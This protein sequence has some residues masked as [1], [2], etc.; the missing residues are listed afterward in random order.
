MPAWCCGDLGPQGSD[1]CPACSPLSVGSTDKPRP[2]ER[3]GYLRP[4]PQVPPAPSNGVLTACPHPVPPICSDPLGPRAP[5]EAHGSGL[6]LLSSGVPS[7]RTEGLGDK[8]FDC[9]RQHPALRCTPIRVPCHPLCPS[10]SLPPHR[11]LRQPGTPRLPLTRA[12]WSGPSSTVY[13]GARRPSGV[14]PPRRAHSSRPRL[15]A[16]PCVTRAG[17]APSA[18][19]PKTVRALSPRSRN[20]QRAAS[21]HIPGRAGSQGK[22]GAAG[23][24]GRGGG[25]ERAGSGRVGPR[26]GAPSKPPLPSVLVLDRLPVGAAV[27]AFQALRRLPP[28]AQAAPPPS[29][30]PPARNGGDSLPAGRQV[31]GPRLGAGGRGRRWGSHLRGATDPCSLLPPRPRMAGHLPTAHGSCVPSPSGAVGLAWLCLHCL[32]ASFRAC[33]GCPC[34]FPLPRGSWVSRN[35]PSSQESHMS[36]KRGLFL[37]DP[38]VRET[39]LTVQAPWVA[40]GRTV[41]APWV[42]GPSRLSG[43]CRGYGPDSLGAGLSSL[44]LS[45][46]GPALWGSPPSGPWRPR[47]LEG[48]RVPIPQAV[49]ACLALC[50]PENRFVLAL[51]ATRSPALSTRA[52]LPLSRP[53]GLW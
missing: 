9:T 24:G 36:H 26:P 2:P 39:P 27:C 49:L 16:G 7:A 13:W 46:D 50:W 23:A 14:S 44:G 28:P 38:R 11:G 29:L 32:P 18:H 40:W 15:C 34:G 17:C 5:S 51:P 4:G 8:G 25:G 30:G 47:G 52:G 43:W 41:Q 3:R 21:R 6:G 12:Q 53:P 19:I 20:S 45:L 42:G 31:P 22:P 48:P 35:R 33:E 37:E 1:G 10:S